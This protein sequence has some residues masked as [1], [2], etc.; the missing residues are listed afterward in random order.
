MSR[1]DDVI[2]DVGYILDC[3]KTLR[4]IQSSGFCN[5]CASKNNCPYEPK[6][7]QLARFNCPHYVEKE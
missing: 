5:V 2:E 4:D 3:L 7:G 1:I 6:L